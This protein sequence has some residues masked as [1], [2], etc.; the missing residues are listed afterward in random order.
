MAVPGGLQVRYV[1]LKAIAFSAILS[2]MA[3]GDGLACS[4]ERNPTAAGILAQSTMV[5]TGI[6]RSSVVVAPGASATTFEVTE[7]FKG[8][9]AKA[10]VVVRHPNGPSASCGVQFETGQSVTLA[11]HQSAGGL[12]TTFCSTWMFLP[13]VGLRD[14]L[15]ADMR[16][17]RT[18]TATAPAS[19]P[20][21]ALATAAA[22]ARGPDGWRI[23]NLPDGRPA[24]F[25][26]G[27]IDGARHVVALA[28]G[29]EK[30][31]EL[32]IVP[33]ARALLVETG[34]GIWAL[35]PDRP[36]DALAAGLIDAADN[37]FKLSLDGKAFPAG[38]AAIDAFDKIGKDC[39]QR[40]GWEYGKDD[41]KQMLWIFRR[42][43]DGGAPFLTFG[44][45]ATGWLLADLSCEPRRQTLIV[46]ST[47]LP[48][49]A[50]N[51]QAVPLK[52]RAGG[53]EYS[54]PARIKILAEGDVPG[55]AVARFALPQRLLASLRQADEISLKT[56]DADMTLPARGAAALLAPL[57]RA[58]GF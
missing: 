38:P 27:T 12:S 42:A 52:L 26:I 19:A 51:G 40:S 36:A 50:K 48:R 16:T 6:A 49:G 56:Q 23:E 47:A 25:G 41:D 34:D 46:R 29:V 9:E 7:G 33:A 22:Q 28:C 11:A 14:R 31:P 43:E 57:E 44:K 10:F 35:P 55:F 58:C 54:A 21:T 15:L 13:H 2:L 5:F 1:H 37:T 30:R 20:A 17:L 39:E 53:Q 45:P 24:A 4:C 18:A 3:I 32:A 8:A